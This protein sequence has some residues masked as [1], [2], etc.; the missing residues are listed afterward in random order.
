MNAEIRICK[1]GGYTGTSSVP[2]R[3]VTPTPTS[4]TQHSHLVY[5]CK[6]AFKSGMCTRY[7]YLILVLGIGVR[8]RC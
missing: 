7:W 6:Q 2:N 5:G 1:N 3:I 8:C 4:N